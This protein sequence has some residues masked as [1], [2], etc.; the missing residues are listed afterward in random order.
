MKV[1]LILKRKES[2]I[3]SLITVK[4]IQCFIVDLEKKK[5]KKKKKEVVAAFNATLQTKVY[6]VFADSCIYTLFLFF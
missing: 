3:Y 2:S 6:K 1:L 5:R 4:K